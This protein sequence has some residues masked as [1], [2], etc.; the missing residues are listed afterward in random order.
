MTSTSRER[1]ESLKIAENLDEISLQEIAINMLKDPSI[2]G[3]EP[4]Y[5]YQL[6]PR[7]GT[8][9]IYSS[10]RALRKFDV[11]LKPLPQT[12]SDQQCAIC[13]GDLT[14]VLDLAELSNGVT[15]ITENRYPAVYPKGFVQSSPH[16]SPESTRDHRGFQRRLY[17]LH[18]VQW[19]H[20]QHGEDWHT[21]EEQDLAIVT[22]RLAFVE[23]KLLAETGSI[24]GTAGIDGSGH[25]F[26]TIFKNFGS[27]AGSSLDHGHQQLLFNNVMPRNGYHNWTFWR[28]HGIPFSEFMLR[29]TSE[30]LWVADMPH[31]V[32]MVPYFMKRP[33]AMLAVVKQTYI[34]NLHQLSD[35][36]LDDLAKAIRLCI[37][38]MMHCM[39]A[40]G[41]TPAYNMA[42]HS[43]PGCGLYVE[44]FPRSQ[45]MGGLEYLGTWLC[46]ATPQ[47]CAHMLRQAIIAD[48][49]LS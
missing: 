45:Q 4:E 21:M 30:D 10:A 22:S 6:D 7:D 47:H 28:R 29:E 46:E 27:N 39:L 33:Y 41:R 8:T 17:G 16:Y 36:C 43:G 42:I 12:V 40:D 14:P 32:V 2:T 1:L 15:F 49:N 34:A 23:H 13:L 25:C 9:V 5:I 3:K 20:N 48:P 44:F 26:L 38:T 35:A 37:R 24:A 19:T 18:L 31:V 11:A